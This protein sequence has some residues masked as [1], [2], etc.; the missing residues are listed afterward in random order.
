MA[1]PRTRE[2]HRIR[3]LGSSSMGRFWGPEIH[4]Q[5]FPSYPLKAQRM[6]ELLDHVLQVRD[7]A[8]RVHAVSGSASARIRS[9]R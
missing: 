4:D 1:Q 5:T 2:R 7:L 8:R 9:R 3:D 6:D